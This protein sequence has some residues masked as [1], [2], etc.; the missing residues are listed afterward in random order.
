MD[1]TRLDDWT[2]TRHVGSCCH[3]SALLACNR[4]TRIWPETLLDIRGITQYLQLTIRDLVHPL[5]QNMR[6][7]Q[8]CMYEYF[9]KLGPELA[10]SIDTSHKIPFNDLKSPC[11]LS[12]QFQYTTPDSIEKNI[13]DLKPK[14]SAGYD[15]L[16]SNLLKEIKR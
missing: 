1:I 10:S 8:A 14:S 3:L 16:S 6:N 12:L 2:S 7:E 13:G 5:F 15:N 4:M 9:T 11:Q